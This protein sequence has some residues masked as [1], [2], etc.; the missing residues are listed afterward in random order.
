MGY[1]LALHAKLFNMLLSGWDYRGFLSVWPNTPPWPAASLHGNCHNTSKSSSLTLQTIRR[2]YISL[3]R[4]RSLSIGLFSNCAAVIIVSISQQI[5]SFFPSLLCLSGWG[6]KGW[7][8]NVIPLLFWQRQC[9]NVHHFSL[10]FSFS[11][12]IHLVWIPRLQKCL[13]IVV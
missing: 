9:C 6:P 8:W 2:L 1:P 3:S 13:Y 10:S 11:F 5:V 12:E 4:A 7:R